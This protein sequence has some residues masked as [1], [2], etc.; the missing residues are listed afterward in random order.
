MKHLSPRITRAGFTLIE[1]L[2]VIGIIAILAS[3]VIVAINPT[4]QLGD[5]RDA[6]RR[7]DVNTI[8]NAVYQYAIDNNGT[9]PT[10]IDTTDRGI[11]LTNDCTGVTSGCNLSALTG[12]YLVSIPVDPSGA[13][14]ND[15][16]Y[17][18]QLTASN[19]VTVSAPEY[20]Q[21]TSL[22]SVTR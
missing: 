3:I 8:L 20:E 17:N 19:R 6:Q 7:S 10:C 12:T 21:A 1:L 9:L 15:T 13:T 5:A 2:L 16:N 14:G 11:C 4:K 18:I 22:I